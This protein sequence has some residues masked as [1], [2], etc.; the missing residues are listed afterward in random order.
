M[1]LG[2]ALVRIDIIQTDPEYLRVQIPKLEN[3]IAKLA[4][5]RRT[6]RCFVLR[7]EVQNDPSLS[8]VLE[9]MELAVLVR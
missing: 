4:G 8:I 1:V 5:L 6:A 2:K 9:R 7:I 3:V